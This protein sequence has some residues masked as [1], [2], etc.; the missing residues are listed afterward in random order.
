MA[1][2]F[3]KATR[4]AGAF[5]LG[6]TVSVSA[7]PVATAQEWTGPYV[8]AALGV[9]V[10]HAEPP[11]A[12]AHLVA[13]IQ[14][15]FR[16]GYLFGAGGFAIG[17]E[18]V[19][20]SGAIYG[21]TDYSNGFWQYRR[22]DGSASLRMKAALPYER[23]LPYV[24]VG[25]TVASAA[26]N[27][28]ADYEI[29]TNILGATAAVGIE[30][31]VGRGWSVVAEANATSYGTAVWQYPVVNGIRQEAQLGTAGLVVGINYRF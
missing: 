10:G 27:S 5:T 31:D 26:Y 17:P 9:T 22:I 1:D 18:L 12:N 14:G 24:A 21:R 19:L 15:E 3:R 4:I 7:G 11:R 25:P 23:F 2:V 13:G 20:S 28:S 30:M 29:S 16:A 8:G 6:A